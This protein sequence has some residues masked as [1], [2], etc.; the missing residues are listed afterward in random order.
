MKIRPVGAEMFH[1][2]RQTCRICV[3]FCNFAIESK[4]DATPSK[5]LKTVN[6]VKW[7]GKIK[8][9]IR[10]REPSLE[11]SISACT[12]SRTLTNP[13]KLLFTISFFRCHVHIS[14][15]RECSRQEL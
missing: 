15:A 13:D 12:H 14:K 5:H 10:K 6:F 4:K 8:H 1:A 9:G 3:A 11:N 7:L 2:D